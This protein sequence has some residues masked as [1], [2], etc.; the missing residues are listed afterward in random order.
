MI[1]NCCK[2]SQD[3]IIVFRFSTLILNPKVKS[4]S[5][6]TSR[7]CM[8]VRAGLS[9]LCSKIWASD[10]SLIHCFILP[11]SSTILFVRLFAPKKI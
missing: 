8:A 7:R 4:D 5:L 9:I 1:F 3:I 6:I 10:L 2:V 11:A